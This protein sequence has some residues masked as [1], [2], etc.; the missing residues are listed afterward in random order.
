MKAYQ[1]GPQNGLSSI[2][3]VTRPDPVAGPGEAVLKVRLVSLNNRDIQV[4]EGRYG[5]KKAEDRIP[6]SEGVGEVVSVGEGVD[7]VKVGD[8]A[9][10]LCCEGCRE[11]VEKDPEKYL[12][13]LDAQAAP[14]AE[15][16]T[17]ETP[18]APA[19]DAPAKP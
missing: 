14:A 17:T 5:A 13:K 3:A 19:A 11:A 9:V 8:R 18:A 7:T 15:P 4:L 6:V 16:A 10:F 12:A 1:W 2:S